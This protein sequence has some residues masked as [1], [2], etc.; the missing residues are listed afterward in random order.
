MF[1]I[2]TPIPYT[3]G[4]PH[5]GHLL[6]G[7]FNDT[8]A[9]FY[10]RLHDGNVLLTM[11]L[12]QHGLK[13]YQTAQKQGITA[14]ELVEKEG[15]VFKNL[16]KKFEVLP[17]AFVE[18]SS[19]KHAA[20]CQIFWQKLQGKGLIYKKEYT[21][22]YNLYDE[23]FVTEKDLNEEGFLLSRPEAKPVEM[24]EENYFF[25]LSA[26]EEKCQKYL[27]NAQILPQEAKTE[28]LSFLKEGLEDVSISREKSKMP[29]GVQV[30]NDE[31][32]VMYV[33]FDAVI[34]YA[35]ACVDEELLEKWLEADENEKS[36]LEEK[37]FKELKEKYPIDLVYFGK[38][39]AK[40]HLVFYPAMLMGLEIDPPIQF[41]RH[42]MIND[43]MGR[44]FSK[45]LGNGV[46]PE[47]ILNRY[48][49]DGSRFLILHEINVAGDSNFSFE[50]FDESFNSHL[51]NNIGNLLMRVTTLIEKNFDGEV[52]LEE[53]QNLYDFSKVYKNLHDL[54]PRLALDEILK[55]SRHGNELLEE[56]KPWVLIKNS[57]KDEAK[58]ILTNLALLLKNIGENLAIFMPET[59]EKIVKSVE[60]EKIEKAQVLFQKVEVE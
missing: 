44:K 14:K 13:I 11:G 18:T 57:Q 42:G 28:I 45:S 37:I 40:F 23:V 3:N 16:W 27:Q 34:N 19:K 55:A 50:H 60:C 22:L 54:E 5:L 9:R 43:K 49:V 20:M 7:V 26:F 2:T 38:D 36:I 52:D 4:K 46:S 15:L 10:K 24:S 48:G 56:T 30:P 25:K 12:D 17:D 31:E 29:W 47:E 58:K 6:E 21:G 51:A 39:I 32:Q 8:I 41:L 53:A 1:I 35:T 59:G 33:W